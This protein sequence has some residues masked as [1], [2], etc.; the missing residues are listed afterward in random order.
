MEPFHADCVGDH[1]VGDVRV[2]VGSSSIDYERDPQNPTFQRLVMQGGRGWTIY[3]LPEDPD[4]LLKL[5]FD[6]GDDVEHASCEFF[7]WAY[8]SIQDEEMGP[9]ENMPNNTLWRYAVE[10]GDE[11]LMEEL[12][13]ANDPEQDGC[14][15]Q[16]DGTPG[17]C[18]LS[19]NVDTRSA[20][21]GLQ[22]EHVVSGVACGRLVALVSTEKESIALLYD[23]TNI[24]SPDV[25][26][27]FQLSHATENKSAG[28]A[29]ND[30]TI[31]EIDPESFVFLSAS[32][33]P[34]GKASV[35]FAGAFSGTLSYWEFECGVEDDMSTHGPVTSA[36]LGWAFWLSMSAMGFVLL[37]I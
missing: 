20:K 29:Y 33:S 7:P 26:Q 25:V 11:D 13:A 6:S 32:E 36:A 10:K 16:G 30:G 18:P 27:V 28:L 8:N 23:I 34:T 22:V 3:E 19:Q 9:G 37:F 2:A 14:A 5:V 4:A 31:G 12:A 35:I 15:D 21:G 17:A 1:C 24:A